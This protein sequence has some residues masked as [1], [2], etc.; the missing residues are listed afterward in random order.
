MPISEMKNTY[1]GRG[2]SVGNQKPNSANFNYTVKQSMGG[3]EGE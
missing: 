3:M 2:A 1:P